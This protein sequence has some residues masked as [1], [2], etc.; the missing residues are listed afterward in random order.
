MCL[1]ATRARTYG[2]LT[3]LVPKYRYMTCLFFEGGVNKVLKNNKFLIRCSYTY[4]LTYLFKLFNL[5]YVMLK[6]RM[7]YRYFDAD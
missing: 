1:Y 4:I 5:N 3:W 6:I 2:G 7:P